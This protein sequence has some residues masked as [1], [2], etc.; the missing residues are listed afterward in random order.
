MKTT[1]LKKP[2]EVQF[3][4]SDVALKRFHFFLKS[5]IDNF[6]YSSPQIELEIYHRQ[7]KQFEDYAGQ[8]EIF[9]RSFKSN[10]NETVIFALGEKGLPIIFGYEQITSKD[11]SIDGHC[12]FEEYEELFE[13]IINRASNK[14]NLGNEEEPATPDQRKDYSGNPGKT[15]DQRK[16]L[17]DLAEQADRI[18]SENITF[19]WGDAAKAI[20]W[21]HGAHTNG[22]AVLKYWIKQAKKEREKQKNQK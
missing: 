3:H 11:L 7:I 14:F 21:P 1:E 12:Y 15:P 16:V 22:I 2:V 6:N 8:F 19:T 5:E 20:N 17:I 13:R 9:T 18:K 10:R 4:L